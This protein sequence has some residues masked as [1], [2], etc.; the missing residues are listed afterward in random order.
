MLIDEHRGIR[1]GEFAPPPIP[2]REFAPPE[3]GLESGAGTHVVAH[4][5]LA[6]PYIG[7]YYHPKPETMAPPEVP[8]LHFHD[9]FILAENPKVAS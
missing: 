9:T 3:S 5:M 4:G 2:L 8:F 7:G 1:A 6:P